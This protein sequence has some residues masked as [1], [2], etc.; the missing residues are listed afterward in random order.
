[1][2]PALRRFGE[3]AHPIVVIDDF[4]GNAGSIREIAAD[5]A[6]SP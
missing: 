6:L 4:T 1:M 2:K 3:G 5:G